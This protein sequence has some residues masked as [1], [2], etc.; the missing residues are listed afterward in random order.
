[1]PL[2]II[3]DRIEKIMATY[4]DTTQILPFVRVQVACSFF[5]NVLSDVRDIRPVLKKTYMLYIH[6]HN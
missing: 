2:S 6:G 4:G 3:C 5:K 1:M